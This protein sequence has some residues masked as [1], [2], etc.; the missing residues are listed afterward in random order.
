MLYKHHPSPNSPLHI[1]TYIF[2]KPI[3]CR[4]EYKDGTTALMGY[5]IGDSIEISEPSC[6]YLLPRHDKKEVIELSNGDKIIEFITPIDK[7]DYERVFENKKDK[8]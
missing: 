7:Y 2:L 3:L 1:V 8:L 5:G 4:Y 6:V